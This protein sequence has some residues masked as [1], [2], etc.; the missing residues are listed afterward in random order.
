MFNSSQKTLILLIS[1][2][3]VRGLIY[4]S[5][6]PPW[7]APD[8]PAHFEAIRLIGQKGL[9]PTQEIYLTTPMHPEMPVSFERFRIWEISSLTPPSAPHEPLFIYYYPPTSSGSVVFADNYPLIY[10][11]LLAP[12]SA[13]SEPLNVVQQLYLL[14]FV[15]LF[16]TTLITIA[17]WLFTRTI[18]PGSTIYAIAASSFI[19]FLPFSHSEAEG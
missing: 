17:A 7:L 14:R 11:F 16:F 3:I 5:I 12:L 2:V 10:H 15:S 9:L 8:E 18:F 4:I 19:I 6:V 1:L 13:L